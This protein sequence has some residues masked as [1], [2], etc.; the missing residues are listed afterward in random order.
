MH[1]IAALE[2]G[3]ALPTYPQLERQMVHEQMRCLYDCTLWRTRMSAEPPSLNDE[4]PDRLLYLIDTADVAV[5]NRAARRLLGLGA[6]A[7]DHIVPRR[8]FLRSAESQS[9][10]STLA[11]L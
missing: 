11:A 5:R 3:T 1:D 7:V 6:D 4:T 8:G 2:A 10:A 9:R